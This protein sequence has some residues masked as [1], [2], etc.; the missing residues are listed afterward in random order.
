MIEYQP[1]YRTLAP[2]LYVE[3]DTTQF[4]CLKA[5]EMN[6]DIY[7]SDFTILYECNSSKEKFVVPSS[8]KHIS[9]FAFFD[10]KNLSLLELPCW[11]ESIGINVFGENKLES[12]FIP[13]YV[14]KIGRNLI[15]DENVIFSP[16]NLYFSY[17]NELL[18]NKDKTILLEG[19][20]WS[21]NVIVPSSV[22]EIAESAFDQCINLLSIEISSSV[23]IVHSD[24]FFDCSSL[25]SITIMNPNANIGL[26]AFSALPSDAVIHI[27]TNS[28]Q[29]ETALRMS[30]YDG[31]I[32]D[33][34]QND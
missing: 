30:E 6:G 2:S 10:C 14:R 5:E 1:K 9:D 20:K 27:P 23:E 15:S 28:T 4:G 16:T 13:D 33:M 34:H 32:A 26:G 19:S 11:L 7:N 3:N 29:L 22:K 12:L 31:I 17:E 24:A 25:K 21:T 18:L 8:V